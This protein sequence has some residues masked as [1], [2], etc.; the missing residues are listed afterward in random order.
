LDVAKDEE[1]K[2]AFFSGFLRDRHWPAEA[3]GLD[4]GCRGGVL[5]KRFT[6]FLSW[7]GV[8]ADSNAVALA[9]ANG[10]PCVE[11][12][13]SVAIDFQNESFDVVMMTEVLEHLP[14]PP[15][16]LREVHRILKRGEG[17][18]M[19]LGSVPLA[20]HLHQRWSVMRG[21][22]LDGDPTHLHYF[23]FRELD[24]MLRHFFARVA[25]QPLRG[26]AARHPNWRLPYQQFVRDIAWAAWEPVASPAPWILK[27]ID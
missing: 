12:D 9:N 19:F 11:M 21:R 23:S 16:S 24:A 2:A 4:V 26:T 27:V 14:Y 22:K 1:K 13:V 8:D 7:V 17:S 6:Q 5:A 25:Y 20:Y 15:I 18:G 3:I 10:I